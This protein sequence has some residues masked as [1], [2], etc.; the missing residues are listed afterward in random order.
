MS[1]N[2][3]IPQM[4]DVKPIDKSG[5][6]DWEKINSVNSAESRKNED[7]FLRNQSRLKQNLERE[8]FARAK[9]ER[10]RQEQ[11]RQFEKNLRIKEELRI[12]AENE[13]FAQEELRRQLVYEEESRQEKERIEKEKRAQEELEQRLAY[14]AAAMAE[15]EKIREQ[16]AKWIEEEIESER[17]PQKKIKSWKIKKDS[18]EKLFSLRD[19]FSLPALSFQLNWSKAFLSFAAM[20]VAIFLGFGSLSFASKSLGIKG[21]VL[22]VS[23][24]G[25][26]NLTSAISSMADQN[27]V[28]SEKQFTLAFENFSKASQQ[29][30]DV[31]G[32]LLDVTRYIPFS[33][34][35][36]SGKNAI[37]AGKH[38][39]A[40][41]KSVNEIVKILAE[42]KNPID[43][44]K[45]ESVSLL[46]IFESVEKNS[47]DA[48]KELDA[49]QENIDKI[50]ID[51]LPK[52]K[53]NQ[54]L[55]LKQGL[56]EIRKML[57]SFLD[58]SY[59]FAD[60]LGGNGPR[61]YLFLFQNNSEMRP[62]GGFIG[63]Y[64]LL[65][66]S[67]GHV[68]D[69]FI[70][71]IFNPDGQ[72]KTKIVPP[73]PI[74]KISAAWSLHDSN[75]F[76]DFPASARK[77]VY[78]YEKTG[79]PT[80]DGVITI[81]PTIL[82]KLLEITGPVEMPDYGVTLD[83]NNFV[84]L[85]QH[86]V[87][88]DYDKE[89]NEPKKILSDL[90]PIVLEK[91]LAN[92]SIENVSKIANAFA[93]GLSEKQILLY[94][95]NKDLQDIILQQG[96]SGR[97][98]PTE[99]DYVSVI[100][101]NINGFKTDAVIEEKIEHKAEIQEDGSITDTVV[102]TRKHT[103]GNSDYEWFNK[104][105]ADY[106]RVYVP[107]G[108]TLLE[109]SG[110]TRETNEPPLDYD[111]LGFKRDEDVQKEENNMTIDPKSGTRIYEESGKTV[112]ANWTY[113]SPQETT[114]ITYKYMLPFKLFK[115]SVGEE[116]QVDSYSLL[117]QKQSG[118]LGSAFVS[119]V[120]YPDSF[121]LK[122]DSLEDV[123]NKNNT[124]QNKTV[125]K[126]DYFEGLVF[127]KK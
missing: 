62:T 103:G 70:D 13:R 8:A 54:F 19:I 94:F 16:Q 27:F 107:L 93:Q 120:E 12:K 52:D 44:S 72:L 15:Q 24:D 45:Q 57:D 76:A 51:D 85:T 90:A 41:G 126:T 124:L 5:N 9:Q 87:E 1:I 106:M 42:L 97:I 50:A 61:K 95:Q 68:K 69:F 74:Q 96:W 108:S 80:V 105:N 46:E 92:K 123:E 28:S 39:S 55:M 21:E 83:A 81:T 102:I 3:I 43:V 113:V 77:A 79:G 98:I 4:F 6:L 109:A 60:L 35:I 17:A 56:P 23:Q 117:A 88:V 58:N 11:I 122:W 29:L 111:T 112:F 116:Q 78:F 86:E 75:W 125:L 127:K 30:D 67:N 20:V 66:I 38:F 114:I 2:R 84:E 40:A 59:V 119:R 22:G 36:S 49:A 26:S 63:S 18:G 89:E 14:E 101:T 82:Q 53:Q 110:Q 31:G 73:K 10:L 121:E 104:V 65:N 71:G 118:S 48:K 32:L 33:S 100:N 99:N 47:A 64:G 25:F 115:V 91:L 34:K 37:E 7:D